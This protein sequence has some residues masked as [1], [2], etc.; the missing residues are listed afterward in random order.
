M[1]LNFPDSPTLNQVYTD[2][3]SGFS[4]KWNGSVWI[5]YESST[6]SNIQEL[7]DISASF[8]GSA[9]SFALTVGGQSITPANTN[10]LIISVGGVMKNPTNDFYISGSN[11][12]FTTA[13]ASGLTFF[14]T[15]LGT[16]LSLNT[17]PDGTV[18]GGS[19]RISTSAV[20]GSATTFTEHLVVSGNARVTGI[21]H[22][23][24]IIVL[25]QQQHLSV[26][27]VD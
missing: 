9:T 19:L 27:E 25:L 26:M 8:N 18:T 15:L 14:G 13:P 3:T 16:A 11:I 21:L 6:A 17:I 5:S 24:V 1:A 2:T 7:D 22:S 20:V 23:M 10:Q 12:V 4:Y